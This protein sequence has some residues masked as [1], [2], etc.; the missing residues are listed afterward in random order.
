MNET[1]ES[2]RLRPSSREIIEIFCQRLR[3]NLKAYYPDM[4]ENQTVISGKSIGGPYA[5]TFR[6]TISS[7]KC[8]HTVFI[9]ICPIFERL[10][11]AR[12]EYET[13]QLLYHK[14][15]EANERCAVSRPLDFF[16]D[17]NAYV[18]ESVGINNFKTYLLK[19]NSRISNGKT[20]SNLLSALSD[21]A[22]WL[23][24]FHDI[25]RL[26]TGINFNSSS[27]LDCIRKEFDYSLLHGFS[28]RKETLNRLDMLLSKL[29]RL[30]GVFKLPCAKWHWDYTPGHIYLDNHRI[31]VIDILGIDN[32]PIYE[33]IGH[34]LAAM[35]V[36]NNLPFYP[37]FNHK[38]VGA[39]LC[40]R[41]L[42][43]YWSGCKL[44]REEF[45]LFSKIYNLKYLILYFGGQYTRVS[46][47]I[48]P[49]AGKFFANIRSARLI[50]EPMVRTIEDIED[51]IHKVV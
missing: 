19:N 16:P 33:D 36:A 20:L 15:P 8:K 27:F 1:L 10:D 31:S 35:T 5:K 37:L 38:R 47:R 50:E 13:L 17:L 12:L 3:D 18:M 23:R 24:T 2:E 30:D 25:T 44:N 46:D 14:M 6:F 42:H 29:I 34:F 9:K 41:F 43:A 39:E 51:L 11:P 32:T 26:D 48:H 4:N 45:I 49:I 40:D 22:L 21:C 28:F 7:G